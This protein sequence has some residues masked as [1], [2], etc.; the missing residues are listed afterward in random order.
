MTVYEPL[1]KLRGGQLLMDYIREAQYKKLDPSGEKRKLID[2]S[3]PER[4]RSGDIVSV[5]YK[6]QKPVNGTII[7]VKRSGIASAILLRNKITGLGVEVNVP[8]FNPNVMR[9]D[10]LRRPASYRPR[11]RHYYIRNSRLDVKEIKM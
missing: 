4:L 3:N 10:I 9:I 5:F 11:N 8:I 2:R 6:N 7:M 1:P